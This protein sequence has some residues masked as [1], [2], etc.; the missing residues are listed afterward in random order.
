MENYYS[1]LGLTRSATQDEIKTSY[2]RLA[3]E[4]H[5]DRH[6]NESNSTINDY[7]VKMSSVSEAYEVLSDETSRRRYDVFLDVGEPPS[8]ATEFNVRRPN[9]SECMFCAHHPVATK[10]LRRNIGLLFVRKHAKFEIRAC[11]GCGLNLARDMQNTTLLQ[12]WYG[13]ISFFA[14]IGAA[15]GN[16]QAIFAFSKLGDPV[17]PSDR[18]ARP[19]AEPS[20]QGK[21]VFARAGVYVSAVVLVIVGVWI[22]YHSN[23]PDKNWKINECVAVQN[24]IVTGVVSCSAPNGGVIVDFVQ[25]QQDCPFSTTNYFTESS[26]DPNP[27]TVVCTNNG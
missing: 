17:P 15:L 27:G 9:A 1:I 8:S 6:Q 11:R 4:F 10:T 18:V 5:P 23:T 2:Y 20:H 12:G 13:F 16:A 24:G 25:N 21:S 7:A 14:N 26:A 22:S 3:K 19:I